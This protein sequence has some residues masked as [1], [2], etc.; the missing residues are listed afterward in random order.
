MASANQSVSTPTETFGLLMLLLSLLLLP[1]IPS[2]PAAIKPTGGK[3]VLKAES[4]TCP[5]VRAF[6]ACKMPKMV[7]LSSDGIARMMREVPWSMRYLCTTAV[8]RSQ[9]QL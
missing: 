5:P 9:E 4:G 2:L 1:N 3:S 7:F 6:M 8:S